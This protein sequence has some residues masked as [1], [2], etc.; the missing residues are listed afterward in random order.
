[1][2]TL[3]A[4]PRVSACSTPLHM[5]FHSMGERH[6]LG[7]PCGAAGRA[8]DGVQD[9][10][11]QDLPRDL[12]GGLAQD[13][14]R[15]C[16][17]VRLSCSEVH[18]RSSC[19]RSQ[20]R[21]SAHPIITS[22]RGWALPAGGAN[23]STG[24]CYGDS[25][26]GRGGLYGRQTTV[27]PHGSVPLAGGSYL[28]RLAC[29]TPCACWAAAMPQGVPCLSRAQPQR[30]TDWWASR[31]QGPST[32]RRQVGSVGP[33]ACARPRLACRPRPHSLPEGNAHPRAA[34][35]RWLCAGLFEDIVFQ[36]PWIEET[37]KAMEKYAAAWAAQ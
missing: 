37:I 1:M 36:W 29:P 23:N 31:L 11:P 34:S 18:R 4:V 2:H 14:L 21:G 8:G 20:H 17:G 19:G 26:T 9:R 13:H 30:R 28:R 33:V 12:F 27:A 22:L 25:G 35:P 3:C 32:A 7:T 6:S 16:A 10:V 15:G 24:T 5:S